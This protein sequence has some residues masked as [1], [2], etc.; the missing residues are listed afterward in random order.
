MD[1]SRNIPP[2]SE[3]TKFHGHVGPGTTIGYRA[4]DIA[5]NKLE[6]SRA[7]R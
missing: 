6:S 4:G 2:F 1:K 7:N 5:I 3:V